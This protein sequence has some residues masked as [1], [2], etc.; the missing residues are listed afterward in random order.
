VVMLLVLL[1][2]HNDPSARFTTLVA[3]ALGV[4]A[5]IPLWTQQA[6]AFF[7]TWGKRSLPTLTPVP[8]V[9]VRSPRVGAGHAL[10]P[11]PRVG[12]GHALAPGPRVG[13]GH[14]LAPGPRVGAGHTW[15]LAPAGQ[16]PV[17][18]GGRPGM[19]VATPRP[20]RAFPVPERRRAATSHRLLPLFPLPIS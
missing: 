1:R 11:G 16:S 15:A 7:D 14:A 18:A 13:A 3:W 12:A 20:A 4:A 17:R 9:S 8:R 2:T 10:A 19:S 5:V 6:R